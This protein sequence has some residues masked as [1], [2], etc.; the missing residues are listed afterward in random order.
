METIQINEFGTNKYCQ[1]KQ[2]PK[3]T[4]TAVYFGK[5][6]CGSLVQIVF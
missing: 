5:T 2:K 1:K 3:K 4:T 6:Q